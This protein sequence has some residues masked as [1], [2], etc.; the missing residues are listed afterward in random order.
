MV[1]ARRVPFPL[2]ASSSSD[3]AAAKVHFERASSHS[4]QPMRDPT[5]A[6]TA[7]EISSSS[8]FY[9][10]VMHEYGLGSQQDAKKA[11]NCYDGAAR[12]GHQTA[13]LYASLMRLYGRGV[14]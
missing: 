9:L 8:R 2:G 5:I 11:L 3:F 7:G 6:P 10:G 4:S 12:S 14:R 1:A 13:R